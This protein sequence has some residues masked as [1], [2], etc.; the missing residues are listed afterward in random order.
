M[1]RI[2]LSG[3]VATLLF[4]VSKAPCLTITNDLGGRIGTYIDRYE[5]VRNSNE[6]VIIDGVCASAC[7]L[8]LGA[9]PRDR[10][11]ATPR[12]RFGFH[13]AYD[14]GQ[15][16]SE[17][18]REVYVANAGASQLMMRT[19]PTAIQRWIQAHHGLPSPD[20]ILWLKGKALAQLVPS[21]GATTVSPQ[22]FNGKGLY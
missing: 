9:I 20:S 18:G 7:T 13:Q 5:A 8:I 6:R 19:Y 1:L 16:S 14:V 12:A 10:I 11:C 17:P 4:S 3:L 22:N 2:L 15:A 21:C